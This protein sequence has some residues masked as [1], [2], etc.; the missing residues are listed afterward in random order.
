MPGLEADQPFAF[1]AHDVSGACSPPPAALESRLLW[2][3]EASSLSEASRGTGALP[4]PAR[5]PRSAARRPLFLTSLGGVDGAAAP[6][7]LL[8]GVWS[9]ATSRTACRGLGGSLAH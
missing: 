7:L 3:C 6:G 8:G 1:V 2:S 9:P 5:I 4:G